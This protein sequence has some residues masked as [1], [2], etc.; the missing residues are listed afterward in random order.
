MTAECEF[1][2][3]RWCKTGEVRTPTFG[4]LVFPARH[5]TCPCHKPAAKET[6]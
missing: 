6:P 3:H 4:D 2:E 5:C 1:G